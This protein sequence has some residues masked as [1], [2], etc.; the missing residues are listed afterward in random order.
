M[1]KN[2]FNY[3]TKDL[4]G[5]HLCFFFLEEPV[6]RKLRLRVCAKLKRREKTRTCFAG[7]L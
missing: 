6:A 7:N 4:F 1:L 3:V 2:Y 5:V